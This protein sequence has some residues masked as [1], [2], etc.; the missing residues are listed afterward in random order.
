MDTWINAQIEHLV[1]GK[2][3]KQSKGYEVV[4]GPSPS[5][6]GYIDIAKEGDWL[7]LVNGHWYYPEQY[8]T[9]YNLAM[10]LVDETLKLDNVFGFHVEWLPPANEQPC[11]A[12]QMYSKKSESTRIQWHS[13]DTIA[14]AICEEIIKIYTAKKEEGDSYG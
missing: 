9:D 6:V 7:V 1:Y 4:G 3:I 13:A 12:F 5:M 2:E 11:V 10:K 8:T 14:L